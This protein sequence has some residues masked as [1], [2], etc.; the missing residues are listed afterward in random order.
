M[1]ND[2][3]RDLTRHTQIVVDLILYDRSCMLQWS[4]IIKADSWP[5]AQVVRWWVHSVSLW[6]DVLPHDMPLFL[7][8]TRHNP[9]AKMLYI[10]V[11]VTLGSFFDF[12][13]QCM[14]RADSG[15]C[16]SVSKKHPG[17]FFGRSTVQ[18][19]TWIF[20]LCI[21]CICLECVLKSL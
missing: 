21:W 17:S 1:K 19:D 15:V 6:F 14:M 7:P 11:S 20:L 5:E 2:V 16:V 18:Q 4:H 8:R 10:D 12:V 13:V 9:S 3:E